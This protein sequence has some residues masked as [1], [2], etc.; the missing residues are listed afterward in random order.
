MYLLICI[1]IVCIYVYV[2]IY[3]YTHTHT[4]ASY[5][6]TYTYIYIICRRIYVYTYSI[7]KSVYL[8]YRESEKGREREIYIYTQVPGSEYHVA[9]CISLTVPRTDSN[10][11]ESTLIPSPRALSRP[12]VGLIP[13]IQSTPI[14]H[15]T[16]ITR[17]GFWAVTYNQHHRPSRGHHGRGLHSNPKP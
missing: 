13:Y 8:A 4:H 3:I 14:Q 5:V 1:C 7:Y 2:Y 11:D 17:S 12:P 16:F 10:P 6:G 15:G 9:G